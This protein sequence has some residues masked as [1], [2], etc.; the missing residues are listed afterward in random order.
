M[1]LALDS[2]QERPI[3]L[4]STVVE[5]YTRLFMYLFVGFVLL[6]PLNNSFELV[7][8]MQRQLQRSSEVLTPLYIKAIKDLFLV[9]SVCLALL[10][11]IQR[12]SCTRIW[13]KRP[14]LL[15]NVF[16]V[17][18]VAESIHSISY[19]PADVILMGVRGYWTILFLYVGALFHEID[20]FKLYKALRF[21]FVLHLGMQAIQ[22][23]TDVGYSVYAEHR[24]P[25][26]FVNP[27]TAAAFALVLYHFG[28]RYRSRWVWIAALLS[29][30]ASNSSAGILTFLL[31]YLI[32][33]PKR[34][35]HKL[36]MY[37]IYTLLVLVFGAFVIANLGAVTGRGNGFYLSLF[38]RIDIVRTALSDWNLYLFG[39]GMGI[40]T[41]QAL[42]SGFADA[43]IP[44]NTFVETLYNMGIFSSLVLLAF[45]LSPLRRFEDKLLPFVFVAFAMTNV[46]F[47][48]NPIVQ[49]VL[50]LMGSRIGKELQRASNVSHTMLSG[51]VELGSVR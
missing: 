39:G 50:I 22:M 47:E 6:V 9:L 33:M 45:I 11:G 41:S 20:E 30:A 48:M 23:V 15:A 36:F 28:R 40:A 2:T 35:R 43:I 8:M 24:S 7:A 3:S 38:S 46:I 49:I 4:Q 16:L 51:R 37:P 21:I 25:G 5:R 14:F 31:Y 12:P 29:L 34:F 26:L 44:D 10:A 32:E 27:S 13:L 42:V 18:V 19:L 17:L 1:T